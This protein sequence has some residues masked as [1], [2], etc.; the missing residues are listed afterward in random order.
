MLS[1]VWFMS[2]GLLQVGDDVTVLDAT[3][4]FVMPGYFF[5]L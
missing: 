4:K 3:G 5:I 1:I 2:D